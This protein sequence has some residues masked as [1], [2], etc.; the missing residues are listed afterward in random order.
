VAAEYHDE[1]RESI[2]RHMRARALS[3]LRRHAAAGARVLD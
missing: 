3:A 2:L 1:Q